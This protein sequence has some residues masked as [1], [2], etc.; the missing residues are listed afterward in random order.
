MV[1]KMFV[2]NVKI[3]FDMFYE[4]HFVNCISLDT[5]NKVYFSYFF[6]SLFY[7]EKK[8]S[9]TTEIFCL[10]EFHTLFVYAKILDFYKYL[11]EINQS[12]LAFILII[13]HN[14]LVTEKL[15]VNTLT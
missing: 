11:S 1:V 4:N 7:H 2:Q 3:Y 15:N 8:S 12:M 5:K 14:L 9:D 6:G 13:L 10:F